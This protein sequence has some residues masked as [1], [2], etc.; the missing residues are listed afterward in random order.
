MNPDKFER[1]TLIVVSGQKRSFLLTLDER[2]GSRLSFRRRPSRQQGVLS[3]LRIDVSSLGRNGSSG[4]VFSFSVLTTSLLSFFVP[5]PTFFCVFVRSVLSFLGILPRFSFFHV[6]VFLPLSYVSVLRYL[7]FT[8]YVP[9]SARF[10]RFTGVFLSLTFLDL[11][12][13]R[14]SPVSLFFRPYRSPFP[15]PSFSGPYVALGFFHPL[16]GGG[17]QIISVSAVFRFLP[18]SR[19]NSL[20]HFKIGKH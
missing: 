9:R 14:S 16:P 7:T 6:Y 1:Y 3:V 4:R 18:V 13:L 10:S 20:V 12:G 5:S 11:Y 8:F 19:S 2:G 17:F 15:I